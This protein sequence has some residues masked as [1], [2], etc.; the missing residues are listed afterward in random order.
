MTRR[1]RISLLVPALLLLLAVPAQA[2]E[3]SGLDVAVKAFSEGRWKDAVEAASAIGEEDEAYAKARYLLGESQ[4]VL[5]DAVAA[6]KAFRAVL[7]KKADAVPAKVGLARALVRQGKAEKAL[8]IIEA[9][10][11]KAPK[12]VD[13]K[14]VLG[15]VHLALGDTK[16]AIAALK[17]AQKAA[18]DDP[19][20]ARALVE[21]YL[22]AEDGDKAEKVAR[23][24]SKA[25][26]KHPMGPF[27]LGL[28]LEQ[29]HED[30]A[31]VDAYD[32]ALARD[33]HF[34]DAHK[35][36]AILCHTMSNSYRNL[37]RIKKSMRHYERYFALGGHDP[38]LEQTY[39]TT[40]G[41]LES[42]GMLR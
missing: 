38:K 12:E 20:V 2:D 30:D 21:A 6:E 32:E 11:A 1:S 17:K 9:T 31:A 8:K 19:Q 36:L 35:N 23:K 37:E 15:E 42:R 28:V 41:F 14:R 18:K 7:A 25:L 4:L 26:S 29:A 33:E 5:G 10:L 3:V 22:R 24:L 34:L 27:L 40:R 13:A 39:K 16:K